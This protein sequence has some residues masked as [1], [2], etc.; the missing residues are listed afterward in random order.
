MIVMDDAIPQVPPPAV[1]PRDFPGLRDRIVAQMDRL[2]KRLAQ[3]ASFA[4]S[5][6]DEVALGTAAS[7]AEKVNVQPS[8]LVRFAKVLGY[9]G[10]SELQSV[11]R[12]RLRGRLSTYDDRLRSVRSHT[13]PA[14]QSAQLLEGFCQASMRS[15]EA[16]RFHGDPERLE[17]AARRLAASE[18]I[19]LIAQRRAFPVTAYLS[20]A[21]GTLGIKSV[22]VGSPAGTE[23]ETLSFATEKDAALAVSFTP[24]SPATLAQVRQVAQRA[25]LVVITDSP[26]SPLATAA[27]LWFEVVE[28]D[29]EG[30]RSL[31]A[32]M[33]LAICLAVAVAEMRRAPKMEL[34]F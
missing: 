7:L 2:P 13:D 17:A 10:F 12:E 29:Y 1:P 32:T 23:V 27:N 21:F 5:N 14:A 9:Q 30:F 16:L 11:F 26:F 18:T 20:Y 6:P 22:L 28:A 19:Y 4:V 8:T 15:L 24:Y 3:V 25:P 34:K 33:T 31:S